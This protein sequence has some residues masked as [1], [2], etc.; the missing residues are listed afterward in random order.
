M[1]SQYLKNYK[2][3]QGANILESSHD[4]GLRSLRMIKEIDPS[5]IQVLVLNGLCDDFN[6]VMNL[7]LQTN[8]FGKE[9]L[10]KLISKFI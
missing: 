5:L 7:N 6:E 9:V 10:Q 8:N 4:S 1:I 3:K 2:E